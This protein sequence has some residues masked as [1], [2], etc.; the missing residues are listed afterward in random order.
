[1][2]SSAVGRDH[3]RAFV[4]LKRPWECLLAGCLM[5][6]PHRRQYFAAQSSERV[7][8]VH[9]GMKKSTAAGGLSAGHDGLGFEIGLQPDGSGSRSRSVRLATTGSRRDPQLPRFRPT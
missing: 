4:A 5:I 6:D 3:P 8:N 1:M 9:R 2:E 7:L